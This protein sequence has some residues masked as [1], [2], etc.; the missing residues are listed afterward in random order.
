MLQ[1]SVGFHFLQAESRLAAKR[2]ARAEAREIRMKEIERQQKEVSEYYFNIYVY[3]IYQPV[4]NPHKAT[5]IFLLVIKNAKSSDRKTSTDGNQSKHYS[6][7]KSDKSCGEESPSSQST[8]SPSLSRPPDP[9]FKIPLLVD[10]SP[11]SMIGHPNL[12]S[13]Q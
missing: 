8:M 6:R 4:Y 1:F 7:S 10:L 12:G 3:Y 11:S 5:V 2:A 13:S 9:T